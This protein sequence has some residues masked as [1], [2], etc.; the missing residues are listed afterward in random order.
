MTTAKA[1]TTLKRLRSE[2]AS[3]HS[4]D[5]TEALDKAIEALKEQERFEEYRLDLFEVR[6]DGR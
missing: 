3:S 5:V 2:G 6:Y 1:I 4:A